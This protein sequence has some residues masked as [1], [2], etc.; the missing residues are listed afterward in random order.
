MSITRLEAA[1]ASRL[2]PAQV[3][4]GARLAPPVVHVVIDEDGAPI[5]ASIHKASCHDFI[6]AA[7]NASTDGTSMAGQWV[8]REYLKREVKA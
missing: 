1:R 8:V 5:F 3:P 6:G 4:R 7:I 2:A